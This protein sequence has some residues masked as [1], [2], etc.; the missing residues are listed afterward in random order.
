MS[1]IAETQNEIVE[2]FSM[3]ESWEDRYALLIDMGR[4]L[5]P[6]P[7]E[8][9][10]DERLVKG[11]QSRVWLL[12]RQENGKMIYEAES[13]ALIVQGL[14]ALLLRIFSGRTPDEVLAADTTFMDRIGL[15]RHLSPT[16]TNGLVSMIKHI[17]V[18][19]EMAL[20]KK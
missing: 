12:A 20:G 9:K 8:A 3:L 17:R 15:S 16:R 7:E 18:Y 11:C 10:T 4:E 2:E 19:A 14:I 1:S 6:L 5:P 13:D